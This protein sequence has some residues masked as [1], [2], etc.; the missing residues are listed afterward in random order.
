MKDD[1]GN[2][3]VFTEKGASATHMTA[4]KNLDVI[5]R[6]PGCAGQASDA[7]S[8]YTHVKMKD[9]PEVL[10]LSEEDCP[11]I[12]I[13]LPKARGPKNWDSIDDTVVPAGAQSLR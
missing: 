1:S 8:A 6:L 3:T 9:A 7:V 2:Y 5:S 12:W 11:K 10:H 4:A 13:S